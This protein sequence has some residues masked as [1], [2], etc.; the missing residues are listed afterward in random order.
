MIKMQGKK[1]VRRMMNRESQNFHIMIKQGINMV[2]LRNRNRN[3][4]NLQIFHFRHSMPMDVE[5]KITWMQ[6]MHI[7]RRD[8]TTQQIKCTPWS[9]R[10]HLHPTI[11]KKMKSF[12]EVEGKMGPISVQA[13]A[14]QFRPPLPE[15]NPNVRRNDGT[16]K[17]KRATPKKK[18]RSATPKP[19]ITCPPLP[20]APPKPKNSAPLPL[21]PAREDTPWPSTGKM[22][23]NLFEDRN[24]LLPKNY[25]ATEKKSE[26]ATGTTS[27][28]P[29]LKEEP[30]IDEQSVVSPK[31]EK[32]R[33]GWPTS[34]SENIIPTTSAEAP[35]KMPPKLTEA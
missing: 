35:S 25:L 13:P 21:V 22:S 30:K 17:R 31:A 1:R 28:R 18:F 24:W 12:L 34:R 3:S 9:T 11:I 14:N 29:P 20:E 27:P 4:I 19:T 5:V 6:G 2:Q 32:C 16:E 33:L 26:N 10:L 8:R 23:E 15:T 7:F